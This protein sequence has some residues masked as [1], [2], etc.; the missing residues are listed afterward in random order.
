[1][2]GFRGTDDALDREIATLEAM[3]LLRLRRHA[4]DLNALDR[5]LQ[6]LKRERVR[7]RSSGAAEASVDVG[8]ADEAG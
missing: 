6:E 8:T 1:M 5:D 4:K 2:G 7:R 3:A